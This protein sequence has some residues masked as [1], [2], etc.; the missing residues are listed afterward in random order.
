MNSTA[1]PRPPRPPKWPLNLSTK[2]DADRCLDRIEAWLEQQIIDRPPVRF[3]KHNIQFEEGE[4]LDTRRWPSLEARWLDVDYQ[5]E[6]YERSIAGKV[7]HGETFPVFFPNLG[8]NVYSAF[9][10][11]HLQFAET[12]SWYEPVLPSL[13]DSAVLQ[14]DPFA[15]RYFKKLEDLTRAALER[16][17][18]RY[19]VGYTDYHPGLDCVAAWRGIPGLCMDLAD[20][21]DRLQPVVELSIRDFE[22]I[23]DHFD[24]LLKAGRQP[25]VTWLGIPSFGK[26]HIPSCDFA[27]MI[28]TRHFRAFSLPCLQREVKNMTH[29]LYHVDGK[30]VAQ[31]LEVILELPEIHAIQWVQGLGKDMPILQWAPLI[32]RI[33]AAGKSVIIDLQLDELEALTGQLRPEGLFLCIGVEEGQE[34]AVLERI[35]RW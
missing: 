6:S 34:P 11:G 19:L 29:N 1:I 31:H 5:L 22:R 27:S 2:P 23:F 25:S 16:C 30:G 13:D 18:D 10:A 7:F 26:L 35:S 33:Q 17:G 20:I 24:A 28:S 9:Y 15:S 32:R 3:Y 14:S 8:P 4:A 12:T 21:P